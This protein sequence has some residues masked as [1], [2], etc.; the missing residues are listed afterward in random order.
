M[1]LVYRKSGNKLKSNNNRFILYLYFVVVVAKLGAWKMSK[2][3]CVAF[4]GVCENPKQCIFKTCISIYSY[5]FYLIY[6]LK[7]DI[8]YS[9]VL[10]Q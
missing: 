6:L 9:S 4:L 7:F 2:L 5:M 8:E 10:V 1:K 3:E